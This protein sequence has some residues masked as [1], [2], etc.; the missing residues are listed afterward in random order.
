LKQT[1]QKIKMTELVDVRLVT[2]PL[3]LIV[4]ANMIGAM[5]IE[6][7]N[8]G[9][10]WVCAA[11]VIFVILVCS[12]ILFWRRVVEDKPATVPNSVAV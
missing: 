12:G 3:M 5:A 2:R 1:D 4:L 10:A 6:N 11:N 7:A 9:A 8:A